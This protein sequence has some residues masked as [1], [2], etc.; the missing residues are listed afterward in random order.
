LLALLPLLP[1]KFLGLSHVQNSAGGNGLFSPADSASRDVRCNANSNHFAV[2]VFGVA[3][4]TY[5]VVDVEPSIRKN[6]LPTAALAMSPALESV[7]AAFGSPEPVR[8][9]TCPPFGLMASM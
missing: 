2:Q 3:V 9:F 1:R 6:K 4:F 7:A 5:S 8:I